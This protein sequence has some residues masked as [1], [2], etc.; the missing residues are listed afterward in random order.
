[1]VAASAAVVTGSVVS[2][3]QDTACSPS[4]GLIS[5]AS[6][7]YTLHGSGF[8]KRL[9]RRNWTGQNRTANW[10]VRACRLAVA[11]LRASG[12]RA[13]GTP[14]AYGGKPSCSAGS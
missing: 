3:S 8:G 5:A 2:N 10:A 11:M 6:T 12:I 14:V 13:R 4:G 7:A 1:M 9:G